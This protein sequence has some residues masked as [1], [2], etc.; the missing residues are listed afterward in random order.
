VRIC[1]LAGCGKI[2]PPDAH[3]LRRYCCPA[4]VQLAWRH[5]HPDRYREQWRRWARRKYHED[6]AWAEKRR[7]QVREYYH[8]R[9]NHETAGRSPASPRNNE[10]ARV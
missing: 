6:P 7:R 2:L 10:D 4:H 9:K 1:A 8:R 3:P 5:R